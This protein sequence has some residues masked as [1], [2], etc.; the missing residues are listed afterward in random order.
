VVLS[1]ILCLVLLIN[2]LIH[3]LTVVSSEYG[4]M[5]S[6]KHAVFWLHVQNTDAHVLPKIYSMFREESCNSDAAP[7]A[8]TRV[9]QV[10][11]SP[12]AQCM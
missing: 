4:I 5:A 12:Q 6:T 7:R 2:H 3:T 8:V 1:S 11:H 9:R 10:G